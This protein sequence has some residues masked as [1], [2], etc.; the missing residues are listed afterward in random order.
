MCHRQLHILDNTDISKTTKQKI[1]AFTATK[2]SLIEYLTHKVLSQSWEQT[3]VVSWNDKIL[4][5]SPTDTWEATVQEEADTK[6]TFHAL[7]LPKN[8]I[9]DI[10]SPDIDV[11][12][13]CTFLSC[14]SFFYKT[15]AWIGI[16]QEAHHEQTYC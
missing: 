6:I 14:S 5:T 11:F 2:S 12:C 3:M 15:R 1:L 9:L 8:S 16:E 10:H 7:Q 13:T 4:S